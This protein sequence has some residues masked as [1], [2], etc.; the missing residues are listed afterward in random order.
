MCVTGLA[1]IGFFYV[2]VTVTPLVNWWAHKLAGPFND[3]TGQTLIVLGGS[4][5]ESGII[6]L[7]SY[8]RSVYA[9]RA[10]ASGD[11]RRIIV[12]GGDP[13]MPVSVPMK[14]FLVCHA[15]PQE[16]IVTETQSRSTR[17]NALEVARLLGNDTTRKVLLTSDYH[18]FRARRAFAKVGLTILPRPIPDSIKASQSWLNR[19]PVFLTLCGETAKI[20]Y[21][22]ARG[23]I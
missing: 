7:N 3:S 15:I 4:V 1:A 10:Y 6:G 23:W 18:M 8:W 14:R 5:Q 13:S 11:F 12:A 17:E 21:Y 9:I 16:A 20:C 22:Y 19:W 2:L